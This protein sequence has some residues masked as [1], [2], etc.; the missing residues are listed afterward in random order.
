MGALKYIFLISIVLNGVYGHGRLKQGRTV[1]LRSGFDQ[2]LYESVL[3]P[4][5]CQAQLQFLVNSDL[6]YQFIDASGKP[7]SG[8]LQGN[9]N[10][11]GDYHQCL[12]INEKVADDMQFQGK[13]CTLRVPINQ[14]PIEGTPTFP[15]LPSTFPTFP[16]DFTFPTAAPSIPTVT[17]PTTEAPTTPEEDWIEWTTEPSE[18]QM[19]DVRTLEK[20]SSLQTYVFGVTGMGE[21]IESRIF[22]IYIAASMRAVVAVCVPHVCTATEAVDFIQSRIAF[23]NFTYDEY[24]CRL[25]DDKPFV[26]ADYVAISIFSFIGL[27]LILSTGYDLIQTFWFKRESSRVNP[28][29]VSF[30][31][32]TNTRRFLTFKSTPGALECVDGIRAISMMWVVVGH[33]YCMTLLGFVHNVSDTV[34]WIS[35]FS[36]TWINS[37]PITVDTFFMLSGVLAVYTVIGKITRMRFIKTIHLFYLNRLLRMFPL[38]ATLVLLQASLFNHVSDGPYWLNQAHAAENCRTYW[39]AALLHIQNYVNPLEICLAQ[40]WY[41][42]V[43]MQLYIICPIILVFM[44][45]RERIAWCALTGIVLLSLLS[46]SLYSFMNDY[47]AALAN[48]KR[49][50]QFQSYVQRYYLNTL[51]RAPPFF[52]GMIYGYLLYLCKDKKIR[53][54][55]LNVIILWF[56]S[57]A[58]M[59]FCIFTIYPV[60][61]LEHTAQVFDN[62]LN[63]YMRAIWAIGLGW[64]IFACVHGYGG[65]INWF[66]SLQIWK[67]PARLSYAVYLVHLPIIYV[68][69]GTW[70]KTYYFTDGNNLYRFMSDL[71]LAFIFAFLLCI[72]IDAPCSTLQKLLMNGGKKPRPQKP[73]VVIEESPEVVSARND[74]F[75]KT[76][77]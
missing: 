40:T 70:V 68:S 22:P 47:S 7:P 19:K 65:P 1:D 66:L 46:S 51:A 57:F 62:F 29:F 16:P 37:A 41:L 25:P 38:L 73:A 3:D 42:S 61:Q 12:R 4:V 35:S 43:D 28:M 74:R 48:P 14:N 44:F 52:V 55:K 13:Y 63:A 17:G 53:I 33:T 69:T 31:V 21:P 15:T 64:V 20:F 24:Y 54:S 49:I 34:D 60:M 45:G 72:T 36:A 32:Y 26:A 23:L 5:Q 6:K 39:W 11:L 18:L 30:S 8:F 27:L 10:D 77:L 75:I 76:T 71:S 9:W 59:A 50:M 56:I 67:L 58:M 2:D